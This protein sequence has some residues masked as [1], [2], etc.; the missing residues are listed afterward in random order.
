LGI[1][2]HARLFFWWWWVKSSPAYELDIFTTEENREIEIL[3]FNSWR[4]FDSN[5]DDLNDMQDSLMPNFQAPYENFESNIGLMNSYR[6]VL[7]TQLSSWLGQSELDLSLNPKNKTLFSRGELSLLNEYQQVIVD[8]TLYHFFGTK[9]AIVAADYSTI[10][11]YIRDN[12]NST[13]IPTGMQTMAWWV[14]GATPGCTL[15][16]KEGKKA[17]ETTDKK[18]WVSCGIRSFTVY[19]KFLAEIESFHKKNGKWK[20]YKTDLTSY[21]TGDA[22]NIDCE[23]EAAIGMDYKSDKKSSLQ[24]NS[25]IWGTSSVGS[26]YRA[27]NGNSVAGSFSFYSSTDGYILQW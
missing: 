7:N 15:W 25:T 2:K 24:A 16:K 27:M 17:L 1:G 13:T 9:Y 19:C 21:L 12:P 8:D 4:S 5:D 22:Y 23:Y 14:L 11:D 18:I 10:A 20:S 3:R 6:K 26:S